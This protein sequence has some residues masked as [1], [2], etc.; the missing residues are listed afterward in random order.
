MWILTQEYNAYDQYGQYYVKAFLEKP[1]KATLREW[2]PF[3]EEDVQ[4]L[5]ERGTTIK[6]KKAFSS[7]DVEWFL[8]ED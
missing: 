8:F 1:D 3:S 5:L 2:H 6:S 4:G 7:S